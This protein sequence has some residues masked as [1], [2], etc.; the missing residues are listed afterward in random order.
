MDFYEGALLIFT[1]RSLNWRF[2]L[3]VGPKNDEPWAFLAQE[4]GE[5]RDS[6][7]N[8]CRVLLLFR[9]L[10]PLLNFY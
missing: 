3:L 5:K 10:S 6:P 7:G 4:A 2:F 8:F 9:L 1:R